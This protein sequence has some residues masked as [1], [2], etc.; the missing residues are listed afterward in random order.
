[1][2][3]KVAIIILNWNSSEVT[4]EC[5]ESLSKISYHEFKIFLVDNASKD[6]E[7][8]LIKT[9]CQDKKDIHLISLAH[10]YGFAEGNNIGMRI[11]AE[12]YS[13]D[14]FLLLNNDTL[15]DEKFLTNLVDATLQDKNIGIAV[16]KIFFYQ[17][18][19]RLY[20]AGGYINRLSGMGEH[21]GWQQKD[22]VKY[23]KKQYVG[24]ANGC[25]MLITS[26]LYNSIGNLNR[27]FFSNIEDVEYSYRCK[28]ANFGIIYVPKSIVVHKEGYA[29][30]RNKGQ[31]FRIYL[32]T[33]NLILFYKERNEWY[34]SILFLPYFSIRWV[35]YMTL[36]LTLS[37]DFE[38]VK[39]LFKGIKDGINN[40]LRFVN[41]PDRT[42]FRD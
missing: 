15:V 35:A 9:Y 39:G 22:S 2:S 32:S 29:S 24:F 31:W 6:S 25:C 19:D 37:K 23:N 20:Y 10:N 34:K 18:S 41:L 30:K 14:Y 42:V 28:S 12:Q 33:R 1:M 40:K 26:K 3:Y 7:Y 11:A 4:I 21:I 13:S 17:P 36:K 16:P 8:E 5:L 38:S 27:S